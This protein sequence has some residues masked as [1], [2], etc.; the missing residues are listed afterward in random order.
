MEVGLGEGKHVKFVFLYAMF[1]GVREKGQ[2]K[3]VKHGLRQVGK[4]GM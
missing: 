3:N 4:R 2:V 1:L